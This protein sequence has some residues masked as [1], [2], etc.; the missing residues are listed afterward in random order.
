MGQPGFFD[1]DERHAVLSAAGKL[2]KR[3]AAAVD[4]EVF[5]PVLDPALARS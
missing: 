2:L 3:L 5:R 1:I 4:V